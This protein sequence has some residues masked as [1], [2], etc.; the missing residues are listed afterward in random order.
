[1]WEI[2]EQFSILDGQAKSHTL[3][4]QTTACIFVLVFMNNLIWSLLKNWNDRKS[5]RMTNLFREIRHNLFTCFFTALVF[6][7]FYE[8][9]SFTTAKIKL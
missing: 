5:L 3:N 9:P 8:L 1:M 7:P 6:S 2:H 4:A